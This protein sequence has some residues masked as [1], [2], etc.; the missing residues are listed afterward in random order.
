MFYLPPP[1]TFSFLTCL[2]TGFAQVSG[3]DCNVSHSQLTHRELV[4]SPL[5]F[6]NLENNP[7]YSLLIVV[8]NIALDASLDSLCIDNS[9]NSGPLACN[10]PIPVSDLEIL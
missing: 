1:M 7:P 9:R 4:V 10:T 5:T 8:C 3:A 2:A 6:V